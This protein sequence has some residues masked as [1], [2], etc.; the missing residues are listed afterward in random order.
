MFNKNLKLD[1]AI[2]KQ[3]IEQLEF[4]ICKGKHDYIKATED[5]I[6][7]GGSG[8][9]DEQF[10]YKYVCKNCGKTITK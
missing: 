2:L 10:A 5:C 9:G 4:M 8:N 1:N 6:T 7:Y 3:R